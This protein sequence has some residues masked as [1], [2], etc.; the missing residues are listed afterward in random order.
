[1][2]I[3]CAC[4]ALCAGVLA[5]T[6]TVVAQPGSLSPASPQTFTTAQQAAD[7]LIAA[8]DAFD[9]AALG[10]I[11]GA[12]GRDLV[13]SG[14][15]VQDKLRADEFAAAAR[16]R[17]AVTMDPANANRATLSV[18]TGDW[19][20]PVP[21]VRKNGKWSFDVKAGHREVVNRRIGSN[22]LDAIDVCRGFVEAQHEY[23]L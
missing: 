4:G 7:A 12:D 16:A 5:S 9:V 19:P 11:L 23:A 17:R 20:L 18:G 2:K 1:M 22:E 8:A 13:V 15:A 21:I 14:D 3:L 6:L 10:T